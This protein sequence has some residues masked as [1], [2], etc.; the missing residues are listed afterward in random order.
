MFVYASCM[1][2]HQTIPVYLPIQYEEPI[3][4]NYGYEVNDA[5]TGDYKRLQETRNGDS[6]VGHYSI[7]QPDGITRTVQYTADNENGF[8][9]VVN[10]VGIP[11]NTERQD[12]DDSRKQEE[13]QEQSWQTQ[14]EQSTSSPSLSQAL[15]HHILKNWS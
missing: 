15:I 12:K 7:L 1:V 8:N 10:N 4:Y 6:V 13:K 14:N 9:A 3:N 2:I 11:S 5:N